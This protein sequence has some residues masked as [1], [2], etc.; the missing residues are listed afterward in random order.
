MKL[1]ALKNLVCTV[2]DLDLQAHQLRQSTVQ[3]VF[4]VVS[5]ENI[6]IAIVAKIPDVG[7]LS[8]NES[9]HQLV[10]L[11]P[12]HPVT[13]EELGDPRD[14]TSETIRALNHTWAHII[15]LQELPDMDIEKTERFKNLLASKY[16]E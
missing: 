13:F 4:R 14:L 11:I 8:L 16:G 3:S 1:E 9:L 12:L 2:L 10:T 5:V 6:C 15:D 7:P